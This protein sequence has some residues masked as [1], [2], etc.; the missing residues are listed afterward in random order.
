MLK[1]A[2]PN[3]FRVLGKTVDNDLV[4]WAVPACQ[5]S[6]C[7]LKPADLTELITSNLVMP[8]S[9]QLGETIYVRY[10]DMATIYRHM[11]RHGRLQD[12]K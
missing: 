8:Y 10:A 3:V 1:T 6:P 2:L 7:R 11:R 12:A 5:V 9:S 4:V